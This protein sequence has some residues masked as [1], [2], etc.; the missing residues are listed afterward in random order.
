M[1]VLLNLSKI[2]TDNWQTVQQQIENDNSQDILLETSNYFAFN[3]QLMFLL[4][5]LISNNSYEY[6]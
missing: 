4:G 3:L 6:S 5:S 2:F 1:N